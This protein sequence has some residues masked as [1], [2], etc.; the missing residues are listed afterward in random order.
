[1]VADMY[2]GGRPR[3]YHSQTEEVQNIGIVLLVLNVWDLAWINHVVVSG[4][5]R[6]AAACLYSR[7]MVSRDVAETRRS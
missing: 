7:D 2:N 6:D 4:R 5:K 1:M 3:G